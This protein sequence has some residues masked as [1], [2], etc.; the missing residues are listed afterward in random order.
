MAELN[1]REKL[2]ETG[3][4]LDKR[5]ELLNQ[6]LDIMEKHAAELAEVEEDIQESMRKWDREYKDARLH[7]IPK[8]AKHRR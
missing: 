5:L 3:S 7:S 2:D 1:V 4:E 6:D 8:P